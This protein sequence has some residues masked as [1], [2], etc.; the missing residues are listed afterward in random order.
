M[1]TQEVKDSVQRASIIRENQYK[2]FLSEVI[3]FKRTNIHDV[4]KKE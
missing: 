4:I 3:E 2:K 1:M